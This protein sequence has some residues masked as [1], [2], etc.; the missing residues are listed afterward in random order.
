MVPLIILRMI[1]CFLFGI[2]VVGCGARPSLSFRLKEA[3]INY[4]ADY[5]PIIV[6]GTVTDIKEW[7]PV[8]TIEDYNVKLQRVS[9]TVEKALRGSANEHI[10]F[11]RYAPALPIRR[12]APSPDF[13]VLG[14]RGIFFL[15]M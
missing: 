2:A 6:L 13:I 11:F 14:T 15:D 8:Q 9:L 1:V 7:T 3:D 10:D 12:N 5:S 4:L